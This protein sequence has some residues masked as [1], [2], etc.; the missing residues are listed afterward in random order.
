MPT[1]TGSKTTRTVTLCVL[2]AAQGMPW[3]FVTIALLSYLAGQGAGLAETAKIS[4]LATL[5]WTFKVLWGPVIDRFTIR[6]MGRRRPWIVFSQLAM[7][8]TLLAMILIGDLTAEFETLAWMVFLHNCFVSLQD[9]SS[10][11][12]AVDVLLDDERG[13]VNGMMW[14][15]SYVGTAIGGAGMGTVIANFG[16]RPA[17]CLQ[18][19]VLFLILCV[20]L[21]VRER[22]G[23]KL[24]P[25]TE[26]D[27]KL[28]PGEEEMEDLGG[29]VKGLF[30]AFAAWP[31]FLGALYAYAASVMV[32]MRVAVMPVF[33]TQEIGWTDEHYAQVEGGAGSAAGVAGALVGGFLADRVGVKVIITFGM[34]G[35]SG[36][37]VAMGASEELRAHESFPLVFLLGTTFL[38]SLMTVASFALF[39]RLCTPAVAGT[40]YT[41]YMA[42]A[43]LAR[44]SGAAIVASI[45]GRGYRTIFL[46]M[47]VAIVVPLLFLYPIRQGQPEVKA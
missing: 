15:S 11:A 44:V 8:A 19:G 38:I 42:L 41:L 35:I 25:W 3:G 29:L 17:F 23:E 31:P 24:L 32:G 4:S 18:A 7:S 20:P 12:L 34:L 37:C 40:Q 5:P 14:A 46:V 9:V 16:L 36:F 28:E 1:L 2:Y 33:Y 22:A 27:A 6:S 26:G 30:G 10:D 21:L 45:E 47:A 39:M 43:N 13:T